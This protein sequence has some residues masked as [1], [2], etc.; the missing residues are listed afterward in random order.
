MRPP[1]CLRFPDDWG[2]RRN[3]RS[4][5]SARISSTTW[6]PTTPYRSLRRATYP[7]ASF[8]SLKKYLV[9]RMTEACGQKMHLVELN[10]LEALAP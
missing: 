8:L 3:S 7:S 5:R 10:V 4:N 2:A 6:V 9:H 1:R